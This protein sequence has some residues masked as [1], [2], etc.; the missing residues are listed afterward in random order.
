MAVPS[1]QVHL[2]TSL[3][4]LENKGRK[5]EKNDEKRMHFRFLRGAWLRRGSTAAETL[6]T[7]PRL[8]AWTGVTWA[9]WAKQS[10]LS[11][12]RHACHTGNSQ[13]AS[14]DSGCSEPFFVKAFIKSKPRF[15][16]L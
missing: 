14:K 15:K 10:H 8:V 7:L 4:T 3:E 9:T 1:L 13:A 16:R 5:N 11:Q 12:P 6:P 2:F